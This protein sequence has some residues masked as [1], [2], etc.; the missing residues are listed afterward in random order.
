MSHRSCLAG[1]VLL[2]LLAVPLHSQ[3]IASWK[4]PS[5]HTTRFVAVDTHVRLEVLDW[6]GSGRPIILL[7]GGGNA[8]HVFDDFVPK[9]TAHYHVYGIIR[10]GFGASGYSATDR[11]ADRLGDDV[12]A[13]VNAL[14]LKRPILVGH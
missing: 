10:R 11:P 4:D 14:N 6:G 13:V 1:S 3:S 9:L 8:A 2:A 5:S 12:V 7:A